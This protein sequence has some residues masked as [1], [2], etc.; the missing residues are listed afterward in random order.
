MLKAGNL[1][2]FSAKIYQAKKESKNLPHSFR[3]DVASSNSCNAA[4]LFGADVGA[5]EKTDARL[6]SDIFLEALCDTVVE[7]NHDVA[8][9]DLVL[10]VLISVAGSGWDRWWVGFVSHIG[11]E[12]VAIGEK[13]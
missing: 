3:V 2:S 4:H 1:F 8:R 12:V 6:C 11:W 13:G 5:V 9:V 10:P 7:S